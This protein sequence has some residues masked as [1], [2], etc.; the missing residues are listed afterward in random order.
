MLLAKKNPRDVG[1]SF[2]DHITSSSP[3]LFVYKG[4]TSWV[5]RYL[6]L[7]LNIT[8]PAYLKT[9][10]YHCVYKNQLCQSSAK[11]KIVKS[12]RA[13]KFSVA[14]II[15][16]STVHRINT[17]IFFV[18]YISRFSILNYIMAAYSEIILLSEDTQG[19]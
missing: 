14:Q 19:K 5:K 7:N 2:S 15:C 3:T 8:L 1:P 13:M 4:S 9:L 18:Y 10:G 11:I 17:I 6:H 16:I 12:L